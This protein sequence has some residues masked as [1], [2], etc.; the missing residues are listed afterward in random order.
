MQ[1][2]AQHNGDNALDS[3]ATN[4][5]VSWRYRGE[6]LRFCYRK[7]EYHGGPVRWEVG[8]VTVDD[9]GG[10]DCP[11]QFVTQVECDLPQ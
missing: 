5:T 1:Q 10:D 3:L 8:R 6:K 7:V 11:V 4:E 2:S 9:G